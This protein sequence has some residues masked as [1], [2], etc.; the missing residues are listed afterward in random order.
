MDS[1][2]INKEQSNLG[3]INSAQY[4]GVNEVQTFGDIINGA[5]NEIALLPDILPATLE[6]TAESGSFT[7][8]QLSPNLFSYEFNCLVP[9]DKVSMRNILSVADRNKLIAIVTDNNGNK[10]ILGEP[11]NGCLLTTKFGT[12]TKVAELNAYSLTFTWLSR[13]RAAYA[14]TLTFLT[15]PPS[16]ILQNG[17]YLKLQ[18]GGYLILQ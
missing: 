11:Q 17:S 10:R 12:G 18:N 7:E 3:G 8:E 16:F 1:I 2:L 6:H 4:F 15:I 5:I 9:R 13:Y 14:N